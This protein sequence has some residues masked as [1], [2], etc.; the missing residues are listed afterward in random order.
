MRNKKKLFIILFVL[1]NIYGLLC[2]VIYFFQENLIFLPTVLTQEHVYEMDNSFEEITLES[3][4]GAQLNGLHFKVENPKGVV[5]YFHGNAGN[6]QRWGELT[7]FFVDKDYSV[8]VMDYRGY[9][10]S[11]GKKSMEA[12]YNDTEIWYDYAKQFYKESEITVYGRSLGT[13]FATYISSK[14]QPKKLILESPFYSIEEVAKSRFPFLP[15]KTLLHYKFP[16]YQYINEVSCPITIYHGT[17]DKV[18]NY[19]QGKKLF[20]SIKKPSKKLISISD[21]GHNDLVN[22]KEYISTIEEEL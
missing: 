2:G 21:G 9:G 17:N 5:L 12:L 1:L 3:N 11:T 22:F 6:L 7:E 13:T 15:I 14:H 16:T 4:D 8:I 20:E 18:I 19:L 10:K